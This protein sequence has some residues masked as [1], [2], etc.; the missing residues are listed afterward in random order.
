MLISRSIKTLVLK[1]SIFPEHKWEK[2]VGDEIPFQTFKST[3]SKG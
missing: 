2:L 1:K 3:T